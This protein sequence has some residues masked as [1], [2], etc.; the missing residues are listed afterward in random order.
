[1][2]GGKPFSSFEDRGFGGLSIVLCTGLPLPPVPAGA[3]VVVLLGVGVVVGV[4]RIV[5]VR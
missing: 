2:G 1:M 5:S 4:M 3:G